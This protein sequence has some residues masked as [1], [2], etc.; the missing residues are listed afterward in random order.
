M[1]MEKK[2]YLKSFKI[3]DKQRQFLYLSF[4]S[5]DFLISHS[6]TF[7]AVSIIYSHNATSGKI[8]ARNIMLQAIKISTAKKHRET[9]RLSR[10]RINAFFLVMRVTSYIKSAN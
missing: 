1:R 5:D 10:A 9:S 8:I 3:K 7:G 4:L 2:R 6:H